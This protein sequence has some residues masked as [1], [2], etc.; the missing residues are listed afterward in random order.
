MPFHLIE[1]RFG[2]LSCALE[3]KNIQLGRGGLHLK[4]VPAPLSEIPMN[5][6]VK[7]MLHFE[8]GPLRLLVGYATLRWSKKNK[9]ENVLVQ[10]LEFENLSAEAA[11]QISSLIESLRPK[12]YIPK[13]Y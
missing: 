12:P 11:E 13:M 3:E 7:I 5:S 9:E 1:K 6:L 4:Q 8:E 2:S 10:G